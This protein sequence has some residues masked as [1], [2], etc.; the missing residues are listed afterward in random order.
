MILKHPAF[1]LLLLFWIPMV[2]IYIKREKGWKPTIR[3]SDLEP[4]KKVP[5]SFFV[6]TRHIVFILRIIGFGL[7]V[8]ALARPQ[9]GQ[10]SEE[11]QTEG[12]DIM[13]VLDISESMQALD[14]QPENRLAVA[15]K[16]IK[17]FI[18]KRNSDRIGLVIFAARSYTKCPLT[19]DYNVLDQFLDEIT[20]TDFS[21]QTAIGTAIATA[22]N[23]LKDSNAKSKVMILLT[24]G[25]NNAGEISPLT[26]AKAAAELGIKIYT[27]GVGKEGKVPMPVLL[28]DPFT[29]RII[30][31]VQMV[32]SDLDEKTLR[33]VADVT[34]AYYFRADSPEKLAEVYAQID[35][36]EKTEIKTK[37]YTSYEEKFYPWL[38]IGFLLILLEQILTNTRY[39]R[40]P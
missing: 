26:A 22:A 9:K 24:D 37:I 32:E 31:Q 20:F 38:W 30:K 36:M 1:L 4:I 23:R 17:E 2:Y 28:Q 40:I 11:I 33:E 3:F 34:K 27:I 13:L 16:T 35:K 25:A 12:V 19:L 7:L 29:G 39:R 5:V 10:S 15:K 18:H 6:K 14:F 8:V 21:Y